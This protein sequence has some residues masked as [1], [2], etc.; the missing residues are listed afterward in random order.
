MK[1]IIQFKYNPLTSLL[2][3]KDELVQY[4]VEKYLLEKSSR[5]PKSLWETDRAQKILR[6]QQDDG[7][8][9]DKRK[10]QHKGINTN[11]ELL[12]TYRHVAQLITF[13]DMNNYFTPMRKAA[14]FLFKTQTKEGDFRGIY[15]NQYSPNYNSAILELLCRLGYY[16]DERVIK[17]FKWLIYIEQEEGGWILPMEMPQISKKPIELYDED[18]IVP[19]KNLPFC[20]WVTGIVLRAF[21]QHPNYK[22]HPSAKKA[23]KLLAIRFF[24][25][26]LYS[27]R[28]AREYW[29]KYSYP[30]WWTDLISA[31]D[32]L[33]IMDFSYDNPNI[34]QALHY[35]LQTQKKDGSWDFYILKAKSFP[36]LHW[37]LHYHLCLI[38]KRFYG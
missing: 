23:G 12:E 13:F 17:S 28:S 29:T 3:I 19:D 25:K 14:D 22:N 35:F 8:W 36:N 2:R 9:P 21:S 16:D 20:H 6:Y 18:P 27:A 15:G 7:S 24:T 33:S 32:S 38:F 31:L 37:W 34:D 4:H 11:Y 5:P 26:D 30:F 1:W 10:K